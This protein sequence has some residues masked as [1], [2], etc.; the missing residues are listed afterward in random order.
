MAADGVEVLAH[1]EM[2][3]QLWGRERVCA[4]GTSWVG[5]MVNRATGAVI[6]RAGC[7]GFRTEHHTDRIGNL[8]CFFCGSAQSR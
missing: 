8:G 1:W 5:I 3:L 4:Q 2:L 7:M 6:C